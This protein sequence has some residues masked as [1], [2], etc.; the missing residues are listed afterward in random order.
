LA[1]GTRSRFLRNYEITDTRQRSALPR[2]GEGRAFEELG[3]DERSAVVHADV[4]HGDDVGMVERRRR[5]RLLLEVAPALGVGAE[6]FGEHL[7]GDLALELRIAR[8]VD[9][10]HR[11][12]A[13]RAMIS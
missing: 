5:A 6:P 1:L 7:H 4:V 12:G 13:M 8:A 2:I 10:T 3:D 9:V 11:A